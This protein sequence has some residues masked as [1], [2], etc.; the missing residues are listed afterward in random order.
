MPPVR[1]KNSST[2]TEVVWT[3]DSALCMWAYLIFSPSRTSTPGKTITI[4]WSSSALLEQW[5]ETGDGMITIQGLA[6]SASGLTARE[7]VRHSSDRLEVMSWGLAARYRE[8]LQDLLLE[9]P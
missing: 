5:V 4:S 6:G 8:V 2:P 1:A 3:F 7:V 9:I